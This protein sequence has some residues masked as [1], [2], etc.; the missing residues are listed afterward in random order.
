MYLVSTVKKLMDT[1][2]ICVCV[3]IYVLKRRV[4]AVRHDSKKQKQVAMC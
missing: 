4:V 2:S 1:L 3:S